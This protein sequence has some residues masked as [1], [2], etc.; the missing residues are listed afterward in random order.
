MLIALVLL[1][2]TESAWSTLTLIW[3]LSGLALWVAPFRQPRPVISSLTRG[4]GTQ[5][6]SLPLLNLLFNL[7]L[8]VILHEGSQWPLLVLLNSGWAFA[9]LLTRALAG[10][11][12][13]VSVGVF[14][15]EGEDARRKGPRGPASADQLPGQLSG[16]GANHMRYVPISV[17][18]HPPFGSIDILLFDHEETSGEYRRLLAHATATGM[19]IWSRSALEEELSGKVALEQLNIDWLRSSNFETNYASVKRVLDLTCTLL[20]LPLLLPLLAVV[21]LLVWINGRRPVMFW[22]ERIGL[23]GAP[24]QI[25]KFRTMRTDT[26]AAPAFATD[27]DPRITPLGAVLRKFRLDELPQFWNVLRGEMSIIGPRPEQWAF[28]ADFEESIPLYP[29]RHWV[30]P[31]ITGWAQVNQGYAADLGQTVEKLRYDLYYVKRLTFWLDLHIVFKTVY[32]ILTGF[33]AR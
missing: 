26:H 29:A 11:P 13:N 32:T 5:F 7:G 16:R 19:P 17:G 23:N 28:A 27:N 18:D 10:Q 9:M 20:L 1:F 33:G 14:E 3:A 2:D 15:G 24:F 31:G 21:A 22:Q 12:K 30:R 4:K 8:L 6:P 25:V